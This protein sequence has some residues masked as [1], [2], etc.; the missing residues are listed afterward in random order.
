M[1]EWLRGKGWTA[2]PFGQGL[3]T[4]KMRDA[5]KQ[6]RPPTPVR[7]M[8]DVIAVKG[9]RVL[10]LDAKTGRDDTENVSLEDASSRAA[11]AFVIAMGCRVIHVWPGGK[12]LSAEEAEQIEKRPGPPHH[13]TGSGTPYHLISKTLLNSLA[14]YL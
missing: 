9:S 13:G 3:L 11:L 12:A 14:D 7:W 4:D 1:I 10:L 8:P 5:L 6:V 2:E